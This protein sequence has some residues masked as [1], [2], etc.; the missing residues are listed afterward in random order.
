MLVIVA[1]VEDEWEALEDNSVS[2]ITAS[3]NTAFDKYQGLSNVFAK[4]W[5]VTIDTAP[6]VWWAISKTFIIE[7]WDLNLSDLLDWTIESGNNI[8]YIVKGGDINIDAN[9]SEINWTFI[10]I[11]VSGVGWNITSDNTDTP[12]TVNGSLYGNLTRLTENRT[13]ISMASDWTINVWTVISY[14]SNLLS[15][16]A[17]LVGQFINDS[18]E[19]Q[20]IAQ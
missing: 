8:A 14:G 20:K 16:P 19:A 13:H 5:D 6:V 7:G 11:P 2:E 12:L 17:P 10:A 18:L 3:T 15:K 1:A 9:V 4:R